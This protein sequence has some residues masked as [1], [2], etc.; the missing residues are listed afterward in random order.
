MIDR[1]STFYG[2]VDFAFTLRCNTTVFFHCLLCAWCY[3]CQLR[4]K[5]FC[6]GVTMSRYVDSTA[7]FGFSDGHYVGLCVLRSDLYLASASSGVMLVRFTFLL[8]LVILHIL[9]LDPFSVTFAPLGTVLTLKMV[10]PA[11]SQTIMLMVTSCFFIFPFLSSVSSC[12][13]TCLTSPLVLMFLFWE[14]A[15]FRSVLALLSVDSACPTLFLASLVACGLMHLCH[16]T[17]KRF[18]Y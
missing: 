9:W 15:L 17:W 4:L 1:I 5:G 10:V 14:W 13:R 8:V 6:G 12:S 18:P 3:S 11:F 7:W 2:P 16:V